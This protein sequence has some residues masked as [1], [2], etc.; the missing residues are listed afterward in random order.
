GE[1]MDRMPWIV[2]PAFHIGVAATMLLATSSA[3]AQ[4]T[5]SI[6]GTVKDT[7]GAVLPGVTVEASS[8]ALIEKSRSVV[9]D[10][11]GNYKIVE[12]RPG[13]YAVTV[14]LP[15]FNTYRREGIDLS[16]GLT[17]TVNADLKVGSLQETVTVTGASPI[18]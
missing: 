10:A 16:S 15:G 13:I 7:T 4:V 2:K 14:S 3:W 17:L 18:V 1:V 9:T 12:L 5:A 6:A 8:P 11:Q